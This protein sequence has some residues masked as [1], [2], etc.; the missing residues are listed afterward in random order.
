MNI[1]GLRAQYR[2]WRV[3]KIR[4]EFQRFQDL[5]KPVEGWGPTLDAIVQGREDFV[6]VYE[7]PQGSIMYVT[8]AIYWDGEQPGGIRFMADTPFDLS[9]DS[10][11]LLRDV[12]GLWPIEELEQLNQKFRSLNVHWLSPMEAFEFIYLPTSSENAR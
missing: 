11:R 4:P 8:C 9:E 12:L 10:H 7:D 5:G 3:R 6:G 1:S 2:Q